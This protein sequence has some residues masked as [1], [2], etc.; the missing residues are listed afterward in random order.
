MAFC[1]KTCETLQNILRNSHNLL[2]NLASPCHRTAVHSIGLGID[3]GQVSGRKRRRVAKRTCK[4]NG[5]GPTSV[6]ETGSNHQII[7]SLPKSPNHL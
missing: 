2:Q 1:E 5:D 3:G 4:R 7:S 6:E